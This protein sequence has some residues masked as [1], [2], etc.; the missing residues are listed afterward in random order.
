[1]I[2]GSPFVEK[3]TFHGAGLVCLYHWARKSSTYH[4]SL[5]PIRGAVPSGALSAPFGRKNRAAI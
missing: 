3:S 5:P 2:H 1:L 4:C